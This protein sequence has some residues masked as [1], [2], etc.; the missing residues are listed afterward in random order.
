MTVDELATISDETKEQTPLPE[1]WRLVR[2]GDIC[3]V[4]TGGTPPRSESKFYGGSIPWI[5]PE[6][7]DKSVNVNS[8][9]EYLTE[10]G[11][12]V[13]RLLPKGS[14]L[15]SCIGN[16]GKL[17]IASTAVA[18]NQQINSLIPSDDIDSLYLYYV[19]KLL[20][21][22]LISKASISL[23]S[24][25]NKSSFSDI[26]IPLPPTIEKQKRI[27]TVLDEQMKATAQVRRVVEEQLEAA[28]L[29]PG[30]FLRSVFESEDAQN[31]PETIFENIAVLQR[32]YDLPSQDQVKGEY[33]IITS[34]GIM[35][36]HEEFRE[37][38]P[39]V[40][41]GRSGSIGKVYYTEQNYFPHNTALFVK[42][43]KGNH[44]RYIYYL[45]KNIDLK[46]V[47]SGTGVP[48]LDRKEVHRLVVRLP[49][50]ETQVRISEY[51]DA[52]TED[53]ENL[54]KSLE[55]QLGAVNKMPPALLRKAFAGE[56]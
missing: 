28:K 40:V 17:A 56:I 8:S 5:K 15:V 47:A 34:S 44:P 11:G 38:A 31:W 27:A 33:P 53:L 41:T 10:E 18:T 4:V 55:S 24:I 1:G 6:D 19:C 43:F 2:L 35:G 3:E 16:I 45:L 26:E 22:T 50:L 32:G 49:E 14:V 7:L 29:L 21:P 25:L 46:T 36:T 30:A 9:A 20:R 42:D 37:Y 54:I 39:G 12:K 48:T 23:V 13:S 51:L 52:I